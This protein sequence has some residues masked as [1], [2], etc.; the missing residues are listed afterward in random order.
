MVDLVAN[1]TAIDTA[2]CGVAGTLGVALLGFIGRER[3]DKLQAKKDNDLSDREY[4]RQTSSDITERFKN[5][6]I[7]YENRITDLVVEVNNLRDEVKK[8]RQAYDRRTQMCA[9]CAYYQQRIK[10]YPEHAAD[11]AT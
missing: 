3:S 8:L 11:T 9:G 4:N 10:D 1:W 5:L 6:M 2:L 7:G